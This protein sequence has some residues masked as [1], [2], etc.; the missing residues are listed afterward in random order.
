MR[1]RGRTD[2]CAATTEHDPAPPGRYSWRLR[3]EK[4]VREQ[5]MSTT[6][7][8]RIRE[9][10]LAPTIAGLAIIW[11]AANF[12][13]ENAMLLRAQHFYGA[14]G[15]LIF[16][17]VVGLAAYLPAA[18]CAVK[19]RV[20]RARQWLLA[21]A[22]VFPAVFFYQPIMATLGP[23]AAVPHGQGVAYGMLCI[24]L[25]LFALG[26]ASR[27]VLLRMM[28]CFFAFAVLWPAQRCIA[29]VLPDVLR[30]Q[31][32]PIGAANAGAPAA[33]T[34]LVVGRPTGEHVYYFIFDSYP[35]RPVMERYFNFDDSGLYRSLTGLGFYNVGDFV[36][37]YFAT[38]LTLT[39][40][41]EADYPV[42]EGSPAPID[43]RDFYPVN[44]YNGREPGAVQ[45]FKALGYKPYFVGNWYAGCA[46]KLDTV[47]D[48]LSTKTLVLPPVLAT[49]LGPTPF[50]V[51]AQW[52]GRAASP[53]PRPNGPAAD[54]NYDATADV[55]RNLPYLAHTRQGS[56]VFA[57]NMPPHPPLIYD[58]NC[59]TPAHA[60][61]NM[62]D[63][64]WN[65]RKEMYIDEVAC[66]NTKIERVAKAIVAEDPDAIIVIQSDHGSFTSLT[67][68]FDPATV[69]PTTVF[70]IS[71]PIN[72]IRA[73][74]ACRQWLYPGMSQINTMRFVL[75]CIQRTRPSYVEDRSYWN[76]AKGATTYGPFVRVTTP[77][78]MPDPEQQ[79]SSQHAEHL[80]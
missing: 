71:W 78:Q 57:H 50:P 46:G 13:A 7:R 49:F 30:P 28:A 52:L 68:R 43:T 32:Q 29:V 34:G 14:A 80:H 56:F 9:L 74:A 18:A 41:L 64:N 33:A 72:F 69:S 3:K 23:A 62:L 2:V 65:V 53:D 38:L 25:V 35:G 75:G 40:I 55:L 16:T 44:L 20:D 8:H 37:N 79:A 22:A 36:S 21:I 5:T 10:W 26:A 48:C 6:D 17:G 11:P 54:K 42:T 76:A 31:T 77:P 73:P 59:G 58:R 24:A 70:E 39:A 19:G 4:T 45:A 1:M 15:P 47:F 66:V 12:Y 60:G 61:A 51:L 67:G 63:F 27:P